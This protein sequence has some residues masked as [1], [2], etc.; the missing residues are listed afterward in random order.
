MHC[1]KNSNSNRRDRTCSREEITLHSKK[2]KW[3]PSEL[4]SM[5]KNPIEV[6]FSSSSL[7]IFQN[8]SFL[9]AWMRAKIYSCLKSTGNENK[10]LSKIA[11]IIWRSGKSAKVSCTHTLYGWWPP[12]IQIS[13]H[14]M[15]KAHWQLTYIQSAALIRTQILYL[16]NAYFVST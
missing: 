1:N 8:N 7:K 6:G 16:A 11:D 15:A 4:D 5:I 10:W 3:P 2:K 14:W 12:K 9:G 13:Y